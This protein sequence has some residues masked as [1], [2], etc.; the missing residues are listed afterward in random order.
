MMNIEPMLRNV[1]AML[2]GGKGCFKKGGDG[3]AS[4]VERSVACAAYAGGGKASTAPAACRSW[5]C[6]RRPAM[7]N[8]GETES[9]G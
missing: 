2:D 3:L 9:S 7:D 8:E 6:S 5:G 1:P 4:A